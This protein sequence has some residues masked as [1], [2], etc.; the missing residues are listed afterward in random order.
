MQERTFKKELKDEK[1]STIRICTHFVRGVI[2]NIL[3]KWIIWSIQRIH[4]KLTI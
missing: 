2:Q 4:Y 1:K 3:P